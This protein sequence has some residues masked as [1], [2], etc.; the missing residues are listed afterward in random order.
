M[1]AVGIAAEWLSCSFESW[2]NAACEL[3]GGPNILNLRLLSSATA[4]GFPVGNN[5]FGFAL[6]CRL[7]KGLA[8]WRMFC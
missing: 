7:V 3:P 6:E 8:Y 1:K 2:H 5:V 4:K